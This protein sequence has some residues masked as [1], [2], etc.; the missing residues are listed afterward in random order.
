MID[1]ESLILN[2]W[3][4]IHSFSEG[5]GREKISTFEIYIQ[6]NSWGMLKYQYVK[7]IS[8]KMGMWVFFSQI[9]KYMHLIHTLM[10]W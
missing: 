10:Q 8:A 3:Y 9:S 2:H 1:T 4:W 5:G 7:Q 6:Q